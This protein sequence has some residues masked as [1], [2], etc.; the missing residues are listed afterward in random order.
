MKRPAQPPARQPDRLHPRLTSLDLHLD[1]APGE[2]VETLRLEDCA[3]GCY[4]CY[5][6]H[7]ADRLLV[8]SSAVALIVHT[9]RLEFNAAFRPREYLLGKTA[10]GRFV[11]FTGGLPGG[12][13]DWLK[14]SLPR[15]LLGRLARERFWYESWDTIDMR[16]RKLRPFE[17]VTVGG[18]ENTFAPDFTLTDPDELVEKVA[19]EVSAFVHAIEDRH[20]R[21]AHVLMLGGKD[22][23][24]I[25]LVPKRRPEQWHVFSAEPNATLSRQWLAENDL[26]VASLTTHDNRNEETP[27]ETKAKII[28]SDLY[29]DPRHM[30]WLPSL[31]R[32]AASRREGCIFWAGTAPCGL[33]EGR[34]YFRQYRGAQRE[35]FFDVHLTRV[36]ALMGNYHQVV[37]NITGCALLSPYQNAAIWSNVY[38]HFGPATIPVGADLRA[39]IGERLAGRRIRWTAGNPGPAPYEYATPVCARDVY[40]LH[41][42][43]RLTGA[44]R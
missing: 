41:L 20:P 38:R 17:H 8:A 21:H 36:P 2:V 22:S 30:R 29:S 18:A 16:V 13:K 27:A 5:Y 4:P 23:Q 25:A 11:R 32:L 40:L 1:F 28:A 12:L 31:Q 24:L 15:P 3:C 6:L 34:R 7:A 44:S 33:H 35:R 19:R 39:R 9:G 37:K 10:H 26:A 43:G 14:A 42:L